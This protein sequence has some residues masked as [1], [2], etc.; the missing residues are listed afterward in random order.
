MSAHRILTTVLDTPIGPLS[1]ASWGDSLIAAG[2]GTG[3]GALLPRLHASLRFL[4][5][6]AAQPADLP[7]LVKPVQDYFDGDLTALDGLPVHQPAS[8]GRQRMWEELRA[9]PPGITV[10]YTELAARAGQPT[11]PRAAGAA[12]AAN[13][14]APV[15]PCHRALRTDGS[16]GGYYYGLDRKRWLLRHEGAIFHD[17]GSLSANSGE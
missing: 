13:L 2:F 1:L 6:D 12:C 9:V 17:P 11:A 15:V 14:I 8:P 5:A 7:W 16:L 3:P 10:T 4:P